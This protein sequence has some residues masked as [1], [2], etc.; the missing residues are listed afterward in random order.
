MTE[1]PRK[2]SGL[3]PDAWWD[4]ETEFYINERGED[5]DTART[6]VILRWMWHGNFKP[7]IA[8]IDAGHNLDKAV[9]N[10]LALM[11]EG[12]EK[13]P[14]RLQPVSGR[15]GRGRAQRPENMIR[16]LIAARAYEAEDG[17]SDEVFAYIAK[18]IG[19]SDRTVRQAVTAFRKKR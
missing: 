5:P 9:L 14:V 15:R 10:A 7:L 1:S 3:M 18:A 2:K 19:K 11:L 8:A 12:D 13:F 17:K 4:V 6:V 16:N